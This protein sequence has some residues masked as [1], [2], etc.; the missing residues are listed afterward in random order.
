MRHSPQTRR[1]RGVSRLIVA[2]HQFIQAI[3]CPPIALT[4][5]GVPP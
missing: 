5:N 4:V 2:G 3:N 1:W